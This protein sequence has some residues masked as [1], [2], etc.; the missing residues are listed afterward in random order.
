VILSIKREDSKLAQAILFGTCVWEVPGLNLV[1]DFKLSRFIFS[2]VF[3]SPSRQMLG[4]Y[5]EL[6]HD[7]FLLN[8]F[9]FIKHDHPVI[10]F[11]K[12]SHL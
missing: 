3:L 8:S 6:G 11:E 5:L 2:M 10:S 7:Q 9:T 4:S 1:Q 12:E